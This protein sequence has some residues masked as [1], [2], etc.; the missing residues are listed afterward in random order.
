MMCVVAVIFRGLSEFLSERRFIIISD[1]KKLSLIT[2][3]KK[4]NYSNFYI[5]EN[6]QYLVRVFNS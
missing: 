1:K 6:S 3:G 5:K 2:M 4:S